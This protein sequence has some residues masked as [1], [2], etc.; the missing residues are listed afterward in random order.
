MEAFDLRAADYLLKP[1][2]L[3]RV[4]DTLARLMPPPAQRLVVERRRRTYFLDPSEVLCVVTDAGTVTVCAADGTRYSSAQTLQE[5]QEAQPHLYRCH[6]EALVNPGHVATLAP[7]AS[8]TYRVILDDPA[9]TE[10]PVARNRAR[11]L[12]TRLGL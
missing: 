1:F 12:K 2:T 6:R 11:A 8:G 10:V 9:K 3:D 5:L 4:Q 7:A